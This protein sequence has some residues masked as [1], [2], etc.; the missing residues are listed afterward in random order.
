MSSA[1]EAFSIHSEQRV[2]LRALARLWGLGAVPLS[3]GG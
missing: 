1:A 2:P 3:D